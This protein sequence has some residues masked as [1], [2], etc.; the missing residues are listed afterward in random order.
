MKSELD[1]LREMMRSMERNL[2]D[3]INGLRGEVSQLRREM[4]SLFRWTIG[5]TLSIL[6]PMWVSII[7][8]ILLKK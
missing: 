8:T 1:S 7:L 2:R 6:I 3:E 5:I 4:V